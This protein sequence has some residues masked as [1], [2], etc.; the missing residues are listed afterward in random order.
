MRAGACG[1]A[2]SSAS[3][4]VDLDPVDV[5]V[6]LLDLADMRAA[7]GVALKS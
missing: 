1:H 3:V 2:C 4:D 7:G 5:G 6:A